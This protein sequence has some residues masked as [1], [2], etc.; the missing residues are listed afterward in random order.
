MKKMNKEDEGIF[1][2]HKMLL[3]LKIKNQ[4]IFNE[5]YSVMHDKYYNRNL[6]VKENLL[7]LIDDKKP[8][9][10]VECDPGNMLEKIPQDI[11]DNYH[12][13]FNAGDINVFKKV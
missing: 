12:K 8:K 6:N 2:G 3:M 7:N 4:Q 13:V 9:I 10:I 11:L 5:F 1:W